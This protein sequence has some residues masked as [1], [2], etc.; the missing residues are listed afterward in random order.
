MILRINDRIRTRRVTFFNQYQ[1]VLAYNSFAS[2]FSFNGYFN[3]QNKEHKDI[4]CIGHYHL[5]YLE[6]G[7]ELILTGNVVSESFKDSAK[8]EMAKFAGYSL[9]GVLE[10]CTSPPSLYPLQSDGLTLKEIASKLIKPFGL[11]MV[12]DSAVAGAM[13]EAYEKTTAEPTQS[14]QEYLTELAAQKNIVISHT[15]KGNLLFTKANTTKKPILNFDATRA[16]SIPFDSMGLDYNGQGMHSHIHVIK[17]AS[18]DGGNAGEFEIRNPYVPFVYRPITIIQSSGDD[19]DT[20]KVARMALSSELKNLKLVITTDRWETE[21]GKIIKPN[22]NITVL[23]PEV[24]LYK[25]STWFIESIAF[26][27]DEKKTTAVLTCVLPEVY[28]GK[29][30]DYMFKGIN[31]H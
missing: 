7:G 17:Q 14:I 15:A 9:P 21:D 30:P 28:N 22:N 3:P 29:T 13:N 1:L 26:T 10:D 2:S 4:Y 23:N 20:E 19:N 18:K 27:G 16:D 24:Y 25:K 11:G 8:K 5:A 6:H 31:L 12:I